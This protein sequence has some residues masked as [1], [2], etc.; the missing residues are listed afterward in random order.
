[1]SQGKEEFRLSPI[2][3]RGLAQVPLDIPAEIGRRGEVEHLG[4]VHET[5]APVSELAGNVQDRETVDPPVG[6]IARDGLAD[7]GEVLRSN[8]EL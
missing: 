3:G 7:F 2:L 6:R 4:N 5:E 8:A 1:M